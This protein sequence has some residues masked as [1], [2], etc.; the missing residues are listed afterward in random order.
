[1]KFLLMSQGVENESIKEALL[2]L[3]GK[4][5]SET[6]LAFIPTA[7]LASPVEKSWLLK[8]LNQFYDLG[9]QN[10]DIVDIAGL[11]EDTYLQ[12]LE[13][14]DLLMFSGGNTMHLAYTI[15]RIGFKKHLDRL[16]ETRVYAGNSAGSIVSTSALHMAGDKHGSYSSMVDLS[17]IGALKYH[18]FQLR[19]HWKHPSHV[20]STEEWVEKTIAEN[21]I[22]EPVYLLD[23]QSAIKVDGEKIEV[24]SEGEWKVYN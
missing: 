4:P 14:A 19:P 8:M 6:N 17:D 2:D 3:L 21:N 11:P 15:K 10:Y 20:R 16:L 13:A 24:V 5:F 9:F 12:R 23:D 22:T 7:S 18:N 1:M